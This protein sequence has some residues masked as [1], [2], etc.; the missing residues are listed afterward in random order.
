MS[1][2]E[3]TSLLHLAKQVI[4]VVKTTGVI[5][6]NPWGVLMEEGLFRE[7]FPEYDEAQYE[8]EFGKRISVVVDGVKFSAFTEEEETK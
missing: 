4:E 6:I 7:T 1:K 5:A 2:I 3:L 8:F